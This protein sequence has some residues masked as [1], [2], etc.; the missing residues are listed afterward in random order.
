MAT[1]ADKRKQQQY[2]NKARE[3]EDKYGIPP[4]TLVGLLKTESEF[5]PKA[6]S[7][8]GAKGIAQ[9]MDTT[10]KAMNID[11]YNTDQAIE[12]AAKY[13]SDSHKRLGNWEDSVL[14]YNMGVAGVKQF[15]AGKRKLLKEQAEY[16]QKVFNNRALYYK[17]PTVKNKKEVFQETAR[18]NTRVFTPQYKYDVKEEGTPVDKRFTVNKIFTPGQYD[19]SYQPQQ[20]TNDVN[21][22]ETP[23][24]NTTFAS[25][26]DSEKKVDKDIQEVEQQTAEQK[27]LEE[28]SQMFA[29]NSEQEQQYNFQ[30]QEDYQKPMTTDVIGMYNFASNFV[31]QQGGSKSWRLQQERVKAEKLAKLKALL[32][33]EKPVYKKKTTDE[34]I[35]EKKAQENTRVVQK[36][37][38]NVR[39]YNNAD[40]FS[41]VARNKTDKE[42]ADERK[43]IR[44]KSDANVLNKYSTE[45]FDTDNWTRQNLSDAAK[46]LESKFR[47]S[48]EPNFFDDYLN[49]AN[50]IGV[51]AANLGQAPLQA[52][53]SDSYI[54]Y[55]TSIGTP[56]TVGAI[57]GLGTQNT[58]QF[59][60]NL[61]N[62][63]A[64]TEEVINKLGNSY[65]PNAYKY[66]PKAFKPNPEAY[67]RQVFGE[68]ASKSPIIT[69]TMHTNNDPKGIEAFIEAKPY[70]FYKGNSDE[71][72]YDL[73]LPF[74]SLSSNDAL[75][76]FNKSRPYY[77]DNFFKGKPKETLIETNFSAK[78]YE[79]FYPGAMRIIS[80][81]PNNKGIERF[82][83]VRVLSPF[84]KKGH[85]LENY[86]IYKKDW[87]KG[88]KPIE[89]PKTAAPIGLRA[90]Y[91][92]TQETKQQGGEKIIDDNIGQ[93]NHPGKVT[94]IS[95]PFITMKD[96]P[97]NILA[98]AD[99]GEKRI[100]KPNEEHYFKNAKT[101]TEYPILTEAEKRFLKEINNG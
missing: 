28:A 32:A 58:G 22:F 99:N 4:Y 66:N 39:G 100:M 34:K 3:M 61:A 5:N 87:L 57:A 86:N 83:N 42:I 77:S 72:L 47:V 64:G 14:S 45:I 60:N 65:L 92:G 10:A 25:V 76:Y 69:R 68:E 88:Y 93:Y 16:T 23:Q 18:D 6:V 63:L 62:P 21:N 56:L 35:A 80:V 12:G 13:L 49:P 98:V 81:D 91:L 51:M 43:A 1:V 74:T 101:V 40:K 78:D 7:K 82:G 27:F 50:M 31:A 85:D 95:S 73:E 24:N 15:K 9:F 96:V 53:Q 37:N 52:Q 48:D 36:D 33:Q 54:P 11:P 55:V 67:Y 2:I 29:N 84:S 19:F 70:G 59:V 41:K 17:K 94:R 8:S 46:G 30:E 38:T 71:I 75:P 20:I 97:Y 89:K 79:D 90:A 44:A 26:P